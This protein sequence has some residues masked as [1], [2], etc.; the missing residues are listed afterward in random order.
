M[1]DII[2]KLLTGMIGSAI[3]HALTAAGGAGC[4]SG[5]SGERVNPEAVAA[6]ISAIIVG[7]AMSWYEKR[8][9]KLP[10]PLKP[11]D[12]TPKA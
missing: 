2:Q 3:R 11:L 10:D 1:K 6:G 7:L 8:T 4:V 12:E 9:R 5:V